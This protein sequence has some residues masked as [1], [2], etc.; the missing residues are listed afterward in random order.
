VKERK[1]ILLPTPRLVHPVHQ[2]YAVTEHIVLVIV[3][4]ELVRIMEGWRSGIK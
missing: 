1:F 3:V 4:A 2:L